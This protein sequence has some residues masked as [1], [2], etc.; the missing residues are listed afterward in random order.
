MVEGLSIWE[1]NGGDLLIAVATS[2]VY[3]ALGLLA[4]SKCESIAKNKGL[5]GHY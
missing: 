5:L 2:I 4:F 1:L 3:L